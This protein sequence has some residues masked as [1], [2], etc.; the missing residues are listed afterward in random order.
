MAAGI[1]GNFSYYEKFIRGVDSFK[2]KEPIEICF[3]GRFNSTENSPFTRPYIKLSPQWLYRLSEVIGKLKLKWLVKKATGL[4]VDFSA[5]ADA[6]I[7]N[8]NGVN[9]VLFPIQFQKAVNDFPFITMNWDAGHKT[10]FAF[11]ELTQNFTERELW[12]RDSIQEALAIFVES[13]NSKLEFSK[14]YNIPLHKIEV[15]PLFP[16]GVIDLHVAESE[17]NEILRRLQLNKQKYFYYP[18]QFWAHKNHYNLILGFKEVLRTHQ[19]E[20]LKLVFSGSDM[21]NKDYILDVIK[22]EGLEKNILPL[23][24][25]SNEEVYTLYKNAIALVMPTFLGPT[26]MPLLEARALGT[27]VIC[28]DLAGHREQCETGAI[29]AEPS[30][31]KQWTDAMVKLLNQDVRDQMIRSANEIASRS[32]FT[33]EQALIHLERALI[34]FSFIRK[35]FR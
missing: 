35:T 17:Q 24:F 23:G 9:V 3:V 30:D 12:Y 29:Y 20:S 1:G 10:T 28:S 15:I 14:Y 34:K 19:S 25:I 16:G 31:P 7:L 18:A 4:S 6:K 22:S 27:P 2:F 26:N 13:E 32:V 8:M 21:G 33:I 11:P 5:K